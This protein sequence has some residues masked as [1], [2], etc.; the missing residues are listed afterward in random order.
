MVMNMSRPQL[1]KLF[2][3]LGWGGRGMDALFILA[4]IGAVIGGGIGA[5]FGEWLMGAGVGLLAGM[6][7]FVGLVVWA[8]RGRRSPER[9]H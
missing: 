5:I 7:V 3:D 2:W 1:R 4:G 8:H 6:T 9:R